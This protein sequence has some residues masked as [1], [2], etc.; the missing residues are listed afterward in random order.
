[1]PGIVVEVRVAVG[2]QVVAGQTLAVLEAMKMQ[3]PM[4]AEADGVVRR[5][6][7]EAGQAVA[8]GALLLEIEAP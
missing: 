3:N 8:G 2:D 4:Q 7:V 5:V 6:L 1:M